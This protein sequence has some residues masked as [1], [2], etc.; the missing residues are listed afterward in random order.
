MAE[1]EFAQ[2]LSE[3]VCAPANLIMEKLNRSMDVVGG[4]FRVTQGEG[5]PTEFELLSG[6]ERLIAETA[7]RLALA[8]WTGDASQPLILI[9]EVARLDIES[10]NAL[11]DVLKQLQSDGAIGQVIACG[12]I[13]RG[14]ADRFDALR[15]WQFVEMGV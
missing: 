5:Q 9:D 6:S 1:A 3:K 15:D 7:M 10:M 12:P 13:D 8:G 4:V 14:R 11:L 2:A